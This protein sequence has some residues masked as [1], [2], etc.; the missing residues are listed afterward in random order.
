MIS[1]PTKCY[2]LVGILHFW[3]ERLFRKYF[4]FC[5]IY[6]NF[7]SKCVSS[8][9][10]GFFY[11]K[12]Y[13]WLVLLIR[14]A[15][16]K[17]LNF[18]AINGASQMHALVGLPDNCGTNLVWSDWGWYTEN[19]DPGLLSIYLLTENYLFPFVLHFILLAVPKMHNAQRGTSSF[20][21]INI[22][23]RTTSFTSLNMYLEWSWDNLS[24]Q[25]LYSCC[26]GDSNYG[27]MMLSIFSC[28]R[29]FDSFI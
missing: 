23:G 28:V 12:F 7:N 8:S 13:Y 27:K 25:Y 26:K 9:F 10:K 11:T 24:C 2:C 17:S 20:K 4:I 21:Y 19:P 14:F 6:F 5:M 29:F 3:S 16:V 15:W 22:Y 18:F 1:N